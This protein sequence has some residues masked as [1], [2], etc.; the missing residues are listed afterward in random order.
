[1]WWSVKNHEKDAIVHLLCNDD[2]TFNYITEKKVDGVVPTR[3]TELSKNDD[4]LHKLK[5]AAG[6]NYGSKL[7]NF[8][9]ALTPYWIN[10]CLP[11]CG[12]NEYLIYVDSDIM[13]YMPP[14]TIINV[15][16]GNSI[17]IHTHRFAQTYNPYCEVGSF[18]VGVVVIKNDN[19][20]RIASKCWIGWLMEPKNLFRSQY[21]KCGDQGY[22]AL[23][24]D[25]WKKHVTVFDVA[26]DFVHL[27][28][29]CTENPQNKQVC[30]FHFSH[31]R[32]ISSTEWA[33]SLKG[34]WNP[35]AQD[36]IKPFYENYHQVIT[37]ILND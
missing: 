17:G 19:I 33:D 22:I 34:E 3:L 31:F 29:W 27:A 25:L 23:I 9:W 28:P 8:L 18:N 36:H 32:Y 15:V 5:E 16:N 24:Y 2:D 14:S 30:F 26:Q 11:L 4:S 10:E 37:S 21:G 35:S 20:G 7:D 1:M 6:S 13:F 12:D